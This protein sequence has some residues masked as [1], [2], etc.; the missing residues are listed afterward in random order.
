VAADE[1]L[2]IDTLMTTFPKTW[3]GRSKAVVAELGGEPRKLLQG[4]GYRLPLGVQ[5]DAL[6][7]SRAGLAMLKEWLAKEGVE[8]DFKFVG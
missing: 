5:T 8:Y 3:A 1:N 6:Q 7:A 2:D 4:G